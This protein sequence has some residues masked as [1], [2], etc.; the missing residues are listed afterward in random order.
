VL[1]LPPPPLQISA[2]MPQPG[3]RRAAEVL[4]IETKVFCEFCKP[5]PP[6]LIYDSG[7][8][9]GV[10]VATSNCSPWSSLTHEKVVENCAMSMERAPVHKRDKALQL[11]KASIRTA[12]EGSNDMFIRSFEKGALMLEHY[13]VKTGGG[14]EVEGRTFTGETRPPLASML[15]RE[16]RTSTK[17][18][19]PPRR[20]KVA[21]TVAPPLS[22]V[23]DR[24]LQ[25]R[26]AGRSE[27]TSWLPKAALVHPKYASPPHPPFPPAPLTLPPPVVPARR[28]VQRANS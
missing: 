28:A 10:W 13:R 16:K 7:V 5:G 1:F 6:D 24:D 27:T 8:D 25:V 2:R 11:L 20:A 23:V 17:P 9:N 19:P 22:N 26:Q 3:S 12:E 15:E 21:A 4:S 14:E 18:P